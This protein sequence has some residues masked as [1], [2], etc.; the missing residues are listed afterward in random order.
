VLVLMLGAAGSAGAAGVDDQAA[1]AAV[2]STVRARLGGAATV[3]VD[4]VSVRLEET[5][6]PLVAMPDPAARVGSVVRFLISEKERGGRTRRVGEL[7]ARVT[8]RAQVAKAAHALAAGSL[9]ET[10]DISSSETEL[11]GLP[12]R[13]LPA[14]DSVIGGRIRRPVATGAIVST[15]DVAPAPLVHAG[16]AV[17]VRVSLGPVTVTGEMVA[18]ESGGLGDIVRVVNAE[19]RKAQRARVVALAEVEMIDVR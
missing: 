8:A 16:S 12:L 2:E 11:D 19:T 5:T 3:T 13:A 7:S 1:I 9:V 14:I 4:V 17:T 18:A 15:L 6:G 10:A